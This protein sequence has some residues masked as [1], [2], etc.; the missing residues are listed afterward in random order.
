MS[1]QE[2]CASLSAVHNLWLSFS[3]RAKW[4]MHPPTMDLHGQTSA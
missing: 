3:I 4:P 2:K 1:F